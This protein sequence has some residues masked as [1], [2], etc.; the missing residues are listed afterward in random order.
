MKNDF[1]VNI[2]LKKPL[3]AHL[4]TYCEDGPRDSPLWFIYEDEIL[5][6]FG[7]VQDSF[8]KRLKNDSRCALSIVDFELTNGVLRH[9]GIRGS[10]DIKDICP[11]RLNRFVGKYLGNDSSSWNTWFVKN[12]VQPINQMVQINIQSIVAKDVSF[13]KTGPNLVTR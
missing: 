11:N 13:F 4:A 5:W 10:A 9:V 7:T 8:I 12:I 2:V 3:M 6:L 1:D